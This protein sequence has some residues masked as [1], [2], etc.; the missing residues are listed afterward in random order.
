MLWMLAGSPEG[1]S[2]NQEQVGFRLLLSAVMLTIMM[3][4]IV[5]LV[6][7][8]VSADVLCLPDCR[9]AGAGI[10]EPIHV[11]AVVLQGLPGGAAEEIL[12]RGREVGRQRLLIEDDASVPTSQ[13]SSSLPAPL[14]RVRGVRA[15]HA[16]WLDEAT[17]SHQPWCVPHQLWRPLRAQP[18]RAHPRTEP[19]DPGGTGQCCCWCSGLRCR[20]PGGDAV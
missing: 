7:T 3:I 19:T 5:N 14:P 16:S 8:G 6:V 9:W 10:V 1:Y 20:T 2:R 12:H 18:G 11:P 17:D 15:W 4:V 13:S